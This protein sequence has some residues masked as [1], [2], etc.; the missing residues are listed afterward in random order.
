MPTARVAPEKPLPSPGVRPAVGFF[1]G[2]HQEE[3]GVWREE[4]AMTEEE[5][6]LPRLTKLHDRDL[7]ALMAA[8]I[9]ALMRETKYEVAVD[10]AFNLLDAVKKR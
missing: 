5:R 7:V 3:R 2:L 6:A 9:M 4:T 1:R 10:H 8:I